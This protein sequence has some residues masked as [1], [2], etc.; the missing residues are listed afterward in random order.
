MEKQSQQV[1]GGDKGT[2]VF[3]GLIVRTKDS[4]SRSD[5]QENDSRPFISRKRS[6]PRLLLTVVEG[7]I[8]LSSWELAV[9]LPRTDVE[10]G[11]HF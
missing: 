8:G 9:R 4:D 3:I 6:I 5:I 1:S 2:G 10:V 11:F 7:N